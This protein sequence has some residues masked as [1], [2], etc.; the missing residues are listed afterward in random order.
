MHRFQIC[1]AHLQV[2]IHQPGCLG[3]G[4][5]AQRGSIGL[6]NQG[7]KRLFTGQ[8]VEPLCAVDRPFELGVVVAALGSV[9]RKSAACP[10]C[11]SNPPG[12]IAPIMA[13]DK[14]RLKNMVTILEVV[15]K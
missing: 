3:N 12:T 11:M 14:M 6:V 13:A 2:P 8:R 5:A 1:A 10:V 7:A 9:I 4:L 15:S